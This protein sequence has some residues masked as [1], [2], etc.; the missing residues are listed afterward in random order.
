MDS[1][2]SKPTQHDG[3]GNQTELTRQSA[4]PGSAGLAPEH[5]LRHLLARIARLWI[6]FI[7]GE[8]TLMLLIGVVTWL[9]LAA[10]GVPFA[11][12]LG[13]TAGVLEIVPNVGPVVAMLAA[14]VVAL[15]K[16][17]T[18]LQISPT[19][20]AGVVVLFYVVVQQV[21]NYLIVPRV[22]GSALKLPAL[23][24]LVG[25]AAGALVGGVPGAVLATPLIATGREVL[26]Y[27]L[28]KRRGRT[29]ARRQR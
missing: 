11:P 8:L 7:R 17:S 6:A 20:L 3:A 26:R 21:E 22:L 13:I 19:L 14:A 15:W 9:G 24:V 25:V 18:Y 23:V 27:V 2:Q 12:Y 1:A 28:R 5:E 10:L 29:R 16:G 4:P